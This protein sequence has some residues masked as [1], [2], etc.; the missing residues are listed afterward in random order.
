MFVIVV[1]EWTN[2]LESLESWQAIKSTCMQGPVMYTHPLALPAMAVY[3]HVQAHGSPVMYTHTLAL[4]DLAPW[5]THVQVH[6]SKQTS[7]NETLV[8]IP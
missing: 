8:L 7:I 5:Y 3:T 6:G 1:V 2:E 4:C